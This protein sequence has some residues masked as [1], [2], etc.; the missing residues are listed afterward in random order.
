MR[1]FS[2]E[3]VKYT[4]FSGFGIKLS[5]IQTQCSLPFWATIFWTSWSSNCFVFFLLDD[6]FKFPFT[7]RRHNNLSFSAFLSK[8]S[9]ESLVFDSLTWYSFDQNQVNIPSENYVYVIV[10]IDCGH[11]WNFHLLIALSRRKRLLIVKQHLCGHSGCQNKCLSK[12][13]SDL[14]NCNN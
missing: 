6:L 4:S 5:T 13:F 10:K 11:W 1:L 12:D 8:P 2:T 3:G 7:G 14:S 9:L